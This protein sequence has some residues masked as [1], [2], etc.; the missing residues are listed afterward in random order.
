MKDMLSYVAF[1]A[2]VMGG[3]PLQD[4]PEI[5]D[6]EVAAPEKKRKPRS[7]NLTSW[8]KSGFALYPVQHPAAVH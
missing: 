2:L 5:A 6:V 4:L 1:G 7:R 3:V 8:I